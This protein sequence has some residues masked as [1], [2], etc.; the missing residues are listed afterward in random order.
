LTPRVAYYTR[1]SS[2]GSRPSTCAAG[3]VSIRARERHGG[4]RADMA[5]VA[6]EADGVI[7]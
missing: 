7:S 2:T 3:E 1:L 5:V 6:L 4:D